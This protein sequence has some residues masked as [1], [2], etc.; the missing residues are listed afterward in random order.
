MDETLL[1]E[2][3]DDA[4]APPVW[5]LRLNRP[6]R[7]N[8][9]DSTLLNQMAQAFDLISSDP[10]PS[11]LVLV[12]A[13]ARAFCAGADFDEL[14]S[15]RLGDGF[16]LL[17]RTVFDALAALPIPTVACI[18]G[19]AIGGGME[20]ALACDLRVC[21]P[22]ASFALPEL[23]LGLTPAAGGMRRLPSLIGSGRAKQMVLFG[24]RI[25]AVQ[26][27]DWGLVSYSGVDFMERGVQAAAA[28]AAED[29]IAFRLAK[30]MLVCADASMVMEF[31]ALT[32]ALLYE[33]KHR[34]EHA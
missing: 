14:C 23:G 4:D 29:P 10:R 28:A 34:R 21:S 18:N 3:V 15:H 8:A 24:Q 13:G 12:G 32:Q 19:A 22:T 33:R 11:A 9:Y 2:V 6:Q 20:L 25:D 31:E 7:A 27:C 5:V 26:A 1:I 16:S 30:K 17:S